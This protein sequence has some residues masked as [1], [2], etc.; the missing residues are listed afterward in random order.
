[1]VHGIPFYFTILGF[2]LDLAVLPPEVQAYL[3][4]LDAASEPVDVAPPMRG[5]QDS[6]YDV[7]NPAIHP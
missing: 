4:E 1:M 3:D 5:T 2:I 6:V 7:G